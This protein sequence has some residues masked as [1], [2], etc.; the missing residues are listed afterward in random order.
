MHGHNGNPFAGPNEGIEERV[1]GQNRTLR[2]PNTV[3]CRWRSGEDGGK[4]YRCLRREHRGYAASLWAVG[5]NGADVLRKASPDMI[6]E[7]V[8][9]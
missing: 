2:F 9:E 1:A 8:R 6:A 7:R 3:K 5:G 4:A